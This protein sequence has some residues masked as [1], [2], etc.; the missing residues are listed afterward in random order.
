M[1]TEPKFPTE[2][3]RLV[4]RFTENH[5]EYQSGD[6]KEAELCSEFLIP[7]FEALGWDMSNRQGHAEAYKDVIHQESIRVAGAHNAPDYCFRIGGTRKFFL[8]AKKPAID[9]VRDASPAYQLRR[10]GWSAKLPLS[11]LTDFE[12]F[13][14]YD[15]RIRPDKNDK[16]STARVLLFKYTDYAE[17]WPEIAGT[18]SREAVLRGSFDKYADSNKK[19]RGTAEVDSAFLAEIENWRLELAKNLALRNESLETRELNFAVQ[20]IIDRIIFLRIAEDRGIEDYGRLQS[21]LN[22]PAVYGR[23]K[24][25]FHAADDRYNSGIFHFE[26]EKDRN[27]PPDELTLSLDVDDKVLKEIIRNL[28]YPDSPYEF[29]VLT[30]DILSQVYEQFLGKVIRLTTGHKAKVEE[31]PEVRKAGGVYYT[32]KYIVDY[33]V[34]QTVGKL[35]EGKTPKTAAKLRI[36]DPAC[37]SGSFLLGAYQYLLDWH[38]NWYMEND[39]KTHKKEIYEVPSLVFPLPA[40]KGDDQS[41]GFSTT[42]KRL[43][44]SAASSGIQAKSVATYRLTISERKKILLNNI[45]GVD[46]DSQAVEVTKL[47]LL[48]KVLEGATRDVLERQRKFFHERALPDLG[49]NIK[50]GNSLIGPDFYTGKQLDLFDDES[51]IRINAFDWSGKDGFPQIMKSGGFDAVI[52]NPP[53]VRQE[54]VSDFKPYFSKRFHSY[55]GLADL[56]VYFLERGLNVAN[57]SGFVG[58]ICSGKFTQ[59]GYA[60]ALREFLAKH[61]ILSILDYG[62]AQLFDGATTYPIVPII[63]RRSG[64]RSKSFFYA[65]AVKNES[66]L[67]E[68]ILASGFEVPSNGLGK[69]P[70]VFVTSAGSKILDRLTKNAEPLIDVAGPAQLGIKTSLNA[71]FVIDQETAT[72]LIREDKSAASIIK[73]YGRGRDIHKWSTSGNGTFLVCTRESVVIEKYP[74]IYQHLKRFE[75]ELKARYEVRRGDY[76]WWVVRQVANTDIFDNRKIVYPDLC[77]KPSFA[78]NDDSMYPNNTVF[79]IQNESL[80]LLAFLNSRTV[81]FWITRNCPANRGSAFR[82]FNHY[83]NELPLRRDVVENCV[84]AE[85][86]GTMIR[87]YA[88][89]ASTRTNH[90]RAIIERQIEATD[91]EIDQLVYQL[92]GLT[93]AEIRIVEEA[94]AK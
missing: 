75:T 72:E 79:C 50:C 71:A 84:L 63:R 93:D 32:P 62:D 47:S 38:L 12:E 1:T 78:I 76:D 55:H 28:Y 7:F 89:L 90:E 81:W 45:Y 42:T 25:L 52:G 67:P 70:W 64:T 82:L 66:L 51:R 54:G 22:G 27:E 18:F 88:K 21:L 60:K 80:S 30:A 15:C 4:E 49:H 44:K 24:E 41:E 69:A 58:F 59:A 19:K 46:I 9:I 10:Y 94:T 40:A 87:L 92:Y 57:S 16:A 65:R 33:I 73:P 48:L 36:L 43:K 37:G 86:A 26:K 31:K 14:V 34:E 17:K 5:D 91:R 85:L 39:P 53:Y 83:V 13:A 35:L 74:S 3:A 6:Y 23:L 8:E 2:I 61:E 29:S 77:S 68:S 20:R 11:I 56:Y